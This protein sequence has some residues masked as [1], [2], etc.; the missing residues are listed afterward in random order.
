MDN[1][2]FAAFLRLIAQ[3]LGMPVNHFASWLF[4]SLI[5]FL[6]EAGS[7]DMHEL[8]DALKMDSYVICD[9][10]EGRAY[11]GDRNSCYFPSSEKPMTISWNPDMT[12]LRRRM[13]S[14]IPFEVDTMAIPS[15][16]SKMEP[17]F[18]VSSSFEVKHLIIEEGR[19]KIDSYTFA[20]G[21]METVILPE[22]LEG[23]ERGAFYHCT[24]L[25]EINIPVSLKVIG[26][27]SF[28][29]CDSLPEDIK[30]QLIAIGGEMVFGK[31]ENKDK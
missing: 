20:W 16:I 15:D 22:G 10:K 31:K 3:K 12:F 5:G 21:H 7:L 24:K 11:V 8:M 18:D 13:L 23:I 29:G 9:G 2:I 25:K 28:A 4:K 26:E 27:E 30:E 17:V 6:M 14:S 1:V 19:T